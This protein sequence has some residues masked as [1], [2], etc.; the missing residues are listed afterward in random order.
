MTSLIEKTALNKMSGILYD[1]LPGQAHPF[2]NQ[3]IS[4]AGVAVDLG[5]HDF[6]TG[7]SKNQQFLLY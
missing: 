4:F 3:S 6:W 2:A 7:G 1:F 5:L